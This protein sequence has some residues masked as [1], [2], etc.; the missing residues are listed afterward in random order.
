VRLSD[1]DL[2]GV[3]LRNARLG[4]ADLRDTNLDGAKLRDATADQYTTWPDGFDWQ[5]AG[6]RLETSPGRGYSGSS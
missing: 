2:R 1:A 5:G 4:S 3:D 6:V